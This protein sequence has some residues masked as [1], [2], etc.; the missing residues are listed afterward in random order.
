[1]RNE[2]LDYAKRDRED[3]REESE[4]KGGSGESGARFP[5]SPGGSL[6]NRQQYFVSVKEN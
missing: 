5:S 1:M 6:R 2:Q 3:A 4:S